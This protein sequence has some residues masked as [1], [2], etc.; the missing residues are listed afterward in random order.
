MT[1]ATRIGWV[2]HGITEWNQ[3][4]KIQ[5]VTD[6]PLSREGVEQAHLLAERLS[7]EEDR[8]DGIYC[9]DLLRAARTAEIISERLGIPLIKDGRLRERAFGAAEGTT[10]AE[11]LSRWGENWRKLV[12]DQ[13]SD[14]DIY[15]RGNEFVRELTEKHAGESWLIVTHGS[16]LARMLQ[17]LCSGLDDFHLLN[18]SLTVLEKQT[19]GW[20]PL[21]HNC[22][23]HLTEATSNQIG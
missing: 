21:L 18:M 13:E 20:M 5:G 22:T 15:L 6:I 16:F 12:P 9:S 1:M 2:R 4:G 11:R 8:W 14:D 3:L 17:S 10:L 23:A 19:D 7:R